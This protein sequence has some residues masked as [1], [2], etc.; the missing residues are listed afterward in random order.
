MLSSG[1]NLKLPNTEITDDSGIV[2]WVG[3]VFQIQEGTSFYSECVLTLFTLK[4][5]LS[6]IFGRRVFFPHLTFISYTGNSTVGVGFRFWNEAWTLSGRLSCESAL[7][8]RAA[9]GPQ[10][11]ARVPAFIWTF[12]DDLSLRSCDDAYPVS[13]PTATGF[14]LPLGFNCRWTTHQNGRQPLL[15]W[16]R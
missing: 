6:N 1:T 10:S 3:I 15:L 8:W 7:V 2:K 5:S 9:V 4:F 14:Q 13:T 11:V 12:S 16:W